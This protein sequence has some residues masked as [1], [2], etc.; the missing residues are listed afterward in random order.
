MAHNGLGRWPSFGQVSFSALLFPVSKCFC[1]M[2][3]FFFVRSFY[4]KTVYC[5]RR[6]GV[7]TVHCPCTCL[8]KVVVDNRVTRT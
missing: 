4:I 1:D 8:Y 2:Q 7:F 6:N 3:N 5:R